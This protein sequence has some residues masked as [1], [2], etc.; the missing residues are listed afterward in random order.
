MNLIGRNVLWLVCACCAL[1]GVSCS[2]EDDPDIVVEYPEYIVFGRFTQ[3]SWCSGETCVELYKVQTDGVYE[4]IEDEFPNGNNLGA[5]DYVMK[6]TTT[7]FNQIM[8]VLEKRNYEDLFTV[9]S[10]TI[11]TMAD[12]NFH[13]YFEYKSKTKHQA[14]VIDGTFDGSVSGALQPFLLDLNQMVQ[15]A[16]F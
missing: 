6:L 3:A 13:Y 1:A 14:W 7:D 11:G 12:G 2:K 4:D 5:T 10:P 15:I 16:Q 8:D 9:S